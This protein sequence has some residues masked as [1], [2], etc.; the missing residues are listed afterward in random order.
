MKATL[1]TESPDVSSPP[2]ER[3]PV[4]LLGLYAMN[5]N[6]QIFVAIVGERS[7]QGRKRTVLLK[8]IRRFGHKFILADHLWLPYSRH[9]ERLEPFFQGLKVVIVGTA[10]P[11]DRTNG[12]FDFKI[13][14]EKV[15]TLWH[16]NRTPVVS[17]RHDC[18]L[19]QDLGRE[20]AVSAGASAPSFQG[21]ID[22]SAKPSPLSGHRP[23]NPAGKVGEQTCE[24]SSPIVLTLTADGLPIPADKQS[25]RLLHEAV[26][27]C[28]LTG[29]SYIK[30]P[31]RFE[32]HPSLFDQDEL[33]P[34]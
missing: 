13:K 23:R 7:C 32:S 4:R 25:A 24:L 30:A 33:D 21:A 16:R 18:K 11:Y 34:L 20:S 3:P 6:C 2:P 22:L 31:V 9:W 15:T 26:T 5:T 1:T 19:R 12:T 29:A 8:D 27:R 10:I 17:D 28:Q 14:V